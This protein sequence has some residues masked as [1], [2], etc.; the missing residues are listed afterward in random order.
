LATE[1]TDELIQ[2]GYVRDVVRSVQERRKEL[3]CEFTDRIELGLVASDDQL[4]A[5]LERFGDYIATETL[6]T[7]LTHEPL[8]GAEAKRVQVADFELEIYLQVAQPG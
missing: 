2:E 5:A 8:G 4:T 1:L 6:A 3:G 7:K